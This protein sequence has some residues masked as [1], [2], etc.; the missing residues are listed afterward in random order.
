MLGKELRPML[1]KVTH[2]GLKPTKEAAEAVAKVVKNIKQ[3]VITPSK[4]VRQP[5]SDLF[6]K[7]YM[8]T[9]A[10]WKDP[11]NAKV[12]ELGNRHL[13]EYLTTLEYMNKMEQLSKGI[14]PALEKARK[15]ENIRNVSF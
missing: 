12:T 13:G 7:G 5:S 3:E 10:F 8:Q 6:D 9:E 4:L 14:Q 1:Q 11:H 15:I 2:D